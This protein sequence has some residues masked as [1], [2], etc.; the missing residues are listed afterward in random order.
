[1]TCPLHDRVILFFRVAPEMLVVD[2]IDFWS[3]IVA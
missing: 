1:M 2:W 3:G